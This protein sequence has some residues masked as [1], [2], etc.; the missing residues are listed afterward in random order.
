[1]GMRCP[2]GRMVGSDCAAL[3]PSTRVESDQLGRGTHWGFWIHRVTWLTV[4]FNRL[5]L[6]TVQRKN[7]G[8]WRRTRQG[9][10][11]NHGGTR[12]RSPRSWRSFSPSTSWHH[13]SLNLRTTSLGRFLLLY[14]TSVSHSCKPETHLPSYLNPPSSGLSL[15][16]H[17]VTAWTFYKWLQVINNKRLIWQVTK[18]SLPRLKKDAI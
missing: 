3:D 8:Y 11:V 16:P 13:W 1:M 6:W 2:W 9:E 4:L 12:R 10:R 17:K 15:K 14:C 18:C 5:S 7:W